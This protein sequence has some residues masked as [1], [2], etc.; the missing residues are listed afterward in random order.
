MSITL[1]IYDFFA[2]LIPGLLYLFVFNEF[3]RSIGRSTLNIVSW[4]RMGQAPDIIL[5]VPILIGDYIIGQIFDP[6]AQ[7]VFSNLSIDFDI[8][9]VLMSIV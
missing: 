4:F 7:R 3:L 8:L 9:M 2:Y 5:F 1:G 6:L